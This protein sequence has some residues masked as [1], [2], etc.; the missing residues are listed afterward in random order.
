MQ[1][2]GEDSWETV[3]E[4]LVETVRRNVVIAIVAGAIAARAWGGVL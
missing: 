4:P 1:V 2:S 3:R